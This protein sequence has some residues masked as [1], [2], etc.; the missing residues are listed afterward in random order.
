[1]YIYIYIYIY[2]Y[3][4]YYIYIYIYIYIY[5]YIYIYI[6]ISRWLE[7][8]RF[9]ADLVARILKVSQYLKVAQTSMLQHWGIAGRRFCGDPVP[10]PSGNYDIIYYM[11]T[12]ILHCHCYICVYICLYMCV[13]VYTMYVC[14]YIYIYI[15]TRILRMYYIYIYIHTTII[16]IIRTYK[17]A[18]RGNLPTPPLRPGGLVRPRSWRAGRAAPRPTY[19]ITLYTNT[20]SHIISYIRL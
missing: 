13:Y 12:M 3:N 19:N 9:D 2:I 17:K 5:M 18:H 8:P 4:V 11:T 20:Q 14:V 10:K 15:Y 16:S 1:M 7:R 6:Y